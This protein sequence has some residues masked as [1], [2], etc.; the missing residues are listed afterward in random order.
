M[1]IFAFLNPHVVGCLSLFCLLSKL[2]NLIVARVYL[3]Y[4]W[5]TWG[6]LVIFL[7]GSH[8]ARWTPLRKAIAN[9]G[10]GSGMYSL[11]SLVLYPKHAHSISQ[12]LSA[13]YWGPGCRTPLKRSITITW[14]L[15]HWITP[16]PISRLRAVSHN[17]T[18]CREVGSVSKITFYLSYPY[19]FTAHHSDLEWGQDP[20]WGLGAHRWRS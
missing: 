11:L 8:V 4:M 1:Y 13:D 17:R 3:R 6:P 7:L 10:R 16:W 9:G 5:P 15:S 19:R 20:H 2:C 18:K 12:M 14:V